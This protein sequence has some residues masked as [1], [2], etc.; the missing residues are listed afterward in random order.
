MK[1]LLR[2]LHAEQLKLKHTLALALCFVAPLTVITLNTLVALTRS[3]NGGNGIQQIDFTQWAIIQCSFWSIL[4]LPLFITLQ[5][6]LLAGVEHS[7]QQWK[8]LLALP[9]PKSV[10]FI[11][12]WLI[13]WLMNALST[14][15]LMLLIPTSGFLLDA[16][17]G[18]IELTGPVPWAKL[19][20]LSLQLCIT[21]SLMLGIQT[22]IAL[23]WRSF[24]VASASGM[25]A[26][27]AGFL[28]AQSS[29][30]GHYY[31]W[32]LPI[33]MFTNPPAH[34]QTALWF[35]GIGGVVSLVAGAWYFKHREMP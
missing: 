23:R 2:G 16:A 19:A 22:F 3:P 1:Y 17:S 27:V 25:V 29:R 12:K 24:T 15:L 32:A 5:S 34:L 14:L 26:T 28:I 21:S 20:L 18:T 35:G 7:N 11:S 4:M 8:N 30:F 9:I 13:L 10:H 33:Q 6:A 31:P